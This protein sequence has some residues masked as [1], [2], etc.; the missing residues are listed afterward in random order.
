MVDTEDGKISQSLFDFALLVDKHAQR[1]K[2]WLLKCLEVFAANDLTKEHDL[3]GL[4]DE[5][6]DSDLVERGLTTSQRA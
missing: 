3:I 1:E 4:R 6:Y 5:D 2:A